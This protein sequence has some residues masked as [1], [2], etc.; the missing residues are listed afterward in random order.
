MID[1]AAL[2]APFP[3]TSIYWK[4]VAF[5]DGNRR[6]L[7]LPHL[8]ARAVLDRLD[9]VCGPFGWSDY[10]HI[11]GRN[12]VCTLTLVDPDT[13]KATTK[14]DV[15]TGDLAKP[16]DVKGAFSDALKRTAVKFG[17]GRYLYQ[18]PKQWVDWNEDKKKPINEPKLPSSAIGAPIDKK[19]APGHSEAPKDESHGK[20]AE[21]P[22]EKP[23]NASITKDQADKLVALCKYYKL[24]QSNVVMALG[25]ERWSQLPAYKYVTAL[26]VIHSEGTEKRIDEIPDDCSDL[27]PQEAAK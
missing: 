16:D 4:A 19:A 25:I 17:V 18:L 24:N 7:M 20:A 26:K 23:R 6:A 3:E 22:P 10:Y 27:V 8:D 15:G 14:T 13:G 12:A 9:A 5:A 2:S 21:P 1:F 11:S